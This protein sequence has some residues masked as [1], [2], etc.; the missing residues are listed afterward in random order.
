M[1]QYKVQLF[2][3][4]HPQALPLFSDSSQFEV[5]RHTKSFDGQE[6]ADYLQA[7]NIV[8]IRSKT[9][10][11]ADILKKAAHIQAIGCF[12]I[13]TDQVDLAAATALG[14]PV[15]NAPYANTRSVAE[16][17]LGQ[18][19]LLMRRVPEKSDA[20]HKG[21]WLKAVDGACEVRGKTLGIIGYGHIGSQ[22]SVLAEGLG[23]R[24]VYYDVLPK[25]PLG[26]AVAANNLNEL[27]KQ[28]DVVTCHVPATPDTENMI[29]A[30]ALATMRGGSFLINA[31]RGLVVDIDALK[32]ALVSG[33]IAGAAIDVFPKEP[34]ALNDIFNSPLQGLPNV[35]LTPHIGGSTVEAQENIGRDVAEKLVRY[36]LTGQTVGAV[37]FPEIQLPSLA[38]GTQRLRHIH[39]NVPGMLG[40]I[41]AILA[42]QKI[43]IAAQALQTQGDLG[44]VVMDLENVADMASLRNA[45]AAIEGTIRVG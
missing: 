26:N 11:T 32:N 27:L 6:L 8:G 5:Q 17:V 38:A 18:I 39:R 21:Q 37:N 4:I 30:K 23:M 22:L 29:N 31:S 33:H 9:A 14:I 34:Q 3:N 35:I 45:M 7:A 13:G 1:S 40:Q 16:L 44:Y 42:A 2:E 25:L 24:V 20:A 28:A 41:N 36:A 19:I 10:L 12:C 43:N 15:F